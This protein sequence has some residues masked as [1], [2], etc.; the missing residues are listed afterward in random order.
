M[1]KLEV[2][3]LSVS[4]GLCLFGGFYALYTNEAN[5]L[6]LK[7]ISHE[8][9]AISTARRAVLH[10]S[11][12]GPKH[13]AENAG[14]VRMMAESVAVDDGQAARKSR[15]TNGLACSIGGANRRREALAGQRRRGIHDLQM[16][17]Q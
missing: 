11:E 3:G 7:N 5:A 13:T 9:S 1:R 6:E 12:I 16:A 10:A 4:A 15:D 8:P 14:E 17:A 2:Y